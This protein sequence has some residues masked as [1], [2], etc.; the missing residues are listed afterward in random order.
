M[1]KRIVA[2]ILTAVFAVSALTACGAEA[3]AS[4]EAAAPAESAPAASEAA[5]QLDYPEKNID[6]I[7]PYGAG[8]SQ[9]T[10]LRVACKYVEDNY[11]FKHSFVIKNQEGGSGEIGLTAAFNSEHDGYT[12]AMFHSPHIALPLVRGEQC[13]FTLDDWM[14]I[15]NF[16]TDPGSWMINS[17]NAERFPDFQAV[18]DAALEAPG[19]ISVACGGVN[20]SEG[21]LIKQI[22]RATGAEFKIVPIDNDAEF[23]SM[24]RG[25]H[26]DVLVTQVGDVMTAIEEGTFV[27]LCVGTS[28]RI[29][30]LP[31][32]PTLKELGYDLESYSMRSLAALAGTP[33]E[34][35]ELLCT[36][37]DEAMQ[38]DEVLAKAEELGV[39]LDY[40]TPADIQ[41]MWDSIDAANRAEWE[42]EPWA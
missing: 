12:L 40:K 3:P 11:G 41:A 1:R 17:K 26:V 42:V 18:V 6:I 2:S 34:I 25:N 32:V 33:D 20:T 9:E 16:M 7:L 38:S 22:Q 15:C 21:R 4:S 35:Y 28:E 5:P 36:A 29:E 31:E 10:L 27:P 37:F 14:P 24:L 8:S 13:A 19:T 30:T 39:V 23:V